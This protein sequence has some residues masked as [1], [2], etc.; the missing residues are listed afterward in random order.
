MDTTMGN[1]SANFVESTDAWHADRIRKLKASD[2]W[3]SLV[4]LEALSTGVNRVGRGAASEVRYDGFP[5]DHV[6][7]FEVEGDVVRF[8][9]FA[10]F[11]GV[12]GVQVNGVPSDGIIRTDASGDPTVLSIGDIRFHVIVRGGRLWVRIKDASAP[13]LVNFTGMDRFPVDEEWR[14]VATYIP[15]G[16]AQFI[17]MD[18][19][20][21]LR[22][23]SKI[24]GRVRFTHR[25]VDVDAVLLDAGDGGS[26][27]RFGDATN[28]K[29]TYVV[30]RY[31]YVA[32]STDGR[33]V[34]LDFNRAYNPPCALTAFATCTIPP[35]SNEFPFGVT[36][37]ERWRSGE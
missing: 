36:A 1:A 8:A 12:G 31:L 19:V 35:D 29:E 34:V 16:P 10:G 28:G 4:A 21:G 26:L 18:T 3:L 6:G 5:V 17:G 2:G 15:A 30:G 9:G 27:L 23:E 14:I 25:G 33:T 11:A 37:G 22:E 32:P 13:T 20:I 24:S 7:T